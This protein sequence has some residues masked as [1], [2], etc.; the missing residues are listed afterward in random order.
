M[1]NGA[2]SVISAR[3]EYGN[4]YRS[5]DM[6]PDIRFDAYR[7]NTVYGE[8]SSVQPPACQILIIIK[9]WQDGIWTVPLEYMSF[10]SDAEKVY[11]GR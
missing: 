9:V 1:I 2:F 10:E 11:S 6:R 3:A 7:S 4:T 8:S 5:G